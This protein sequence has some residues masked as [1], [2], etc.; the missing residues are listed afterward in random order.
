MGRKAY[1]TRIA[2]G[3]GSVRRKI[4]TRK[5]GKK[6]E[7]WEARYTIG[8]D[9]DGKQVQKTVTAKTQAECVQKLNDLISEY[10]TIQQKPV[11]S[12]TVLVKDWL[13][14]W[15]TD[16]L[17]HVTSGTAFE[18]GRK[19]ELY[20]VPAIGDIP[21]NKL[22]NHDI[23][24]MINRM[25]E[26]RNRRG[27][28]L[29]PKTV[30]DTYGVLH[31]ALAQAVAIGLIRRNPAENCSLPKQKKPTLAHF[32]TEHLAAFLAAIHGHCHENYY[33]T[34]LFTGMREA[35]GLGLTWD[36]VNFERGTIEINKQ[37][38]RNRKTG[39]Y[40]LV[41]PK[42]DE[43]RVIVAPGALMEVLK[44]QKASE[45]EK[46][47]RCRDLWSERNLVFSNPVGDF[48]S[49]RT[50]YDCYK[51]IVKSIGIP[52]VRLHELRHAY[53][54]LALGNGDDIKTVQRNLGH[55]TPDFTLKVYAYSSMDMQRSSA[56]KMSRRMD[57]L[58]GRDDSSS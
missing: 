9:A 2:N 39:E 18:Y 55:A 6:Y 11:I 15:K 30:K 49:Y 58:S 42:D 34:L 33:K 19:I 17:N 44:Q 13:N 5:G 47:R 8:Y 48:L 53:T 57:A 41:P 38:Q 7:F 10:G 12:G 40:E 28:P 29:S 51:R 4:T 31:K 37:L 16:Y 54:A 43:Y 35:E 14:T 23:Q 52:A 3:Q 50:V 32:E 26:S 1:R 46:R 22:K 21:L 45:D 56:D 36:C 27:E 25:I 24:G 20:I